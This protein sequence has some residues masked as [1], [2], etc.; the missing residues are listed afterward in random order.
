MFAFGCGV[1]LVI[2]W[3][4]LGRLGDLCPLAFA[5]FDLRREFP[6]TISMPIHVR[7]LKHVRVKGAPESDQPARGFIGPGGGAGGRGAAVAAAA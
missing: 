6:Q 3:L 2:Y 5:P 4:D 7:R 1:S